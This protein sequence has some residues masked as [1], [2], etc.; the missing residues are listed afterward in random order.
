[1]GIPI[2][3][4]HDEMQGAPELT[5]D[6][7]SMIA[8]LDACLLNGFNLLTLDTLTYDSQTGEATGTTSSSH[9]FVRDQ[10]ILING[11]DQA[12][13]NGEQRVTW[14]DSASFRYKPAAA[15][16]A[17]TA[18]GTISAKAAPVGNWEKKYDDGLGTKAAYRSI[19][20]AATGIFL[21]VD[22]TNNPNGATSS[23]YHAE[24]R[25]CVSMTDVDTWGE[26]FW[27]SDDY[28]WFHKVYSTSYTPQWT[29][30]GD[31]RL[32]YL[33]VAPNPTDYLGHINAFGDI[34]SVRPG[35]AYHAI[36][37][38]S[39]YGYNYGTDF[40]SINQSGRSGFQL[41]R[42][43]HQLA[44]GSVNCGFYGSALSNYL[45]YNGIGFPNLADNGLWLHQPVLVQESGNVLRGRAP[46]VIQCVQQPEFEHNH[47]L[48]DVN[49]KAGSRFISLASSRSYSSDPVSSASPASAIFDLIGPWR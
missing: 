42:P 2:K 13:Y 3:W 34:V 36:L 40:C 22:D 41:A 17:T 16:S 18:T 38:S 30:I 11:A 15:P 14:I 29:L 23:G 24:V 31:G 27:Y 35:D 39:R 9:G 12:E 45:G 20:P 37:I 1:M 4:F 49:G 44:S 8:L 47:I 19:D 33:F 7:G 43:Y 6:P 48:R 28:K 21:R 5:Q 10:V 46:G 26:S 25:G 32:F